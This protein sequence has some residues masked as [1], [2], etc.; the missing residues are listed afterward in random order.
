MKLARLVI[1][2]RKGIMSSRP[3]KTTGSLSVGISPQPTACPRVNVAFADQI[4][5]KS[6]DKREMEDFR[7]YQAALQANPEVARKIA[8]NRLLL[9]LLPALLGIA[10]VVIVLL[11]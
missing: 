5:D 2:I 9:V 3:R 8:R 10:F 7:N 1:T 11:I 4:M 6:S